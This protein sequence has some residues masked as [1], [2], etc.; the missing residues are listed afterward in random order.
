[1]AIERFLEIVCEAAHKLPQEIKQ[2]APDIDWRAM[3]DFAN[4]LRHAYHATN[5]DIVWNI[6]QHHLPALRAFVE[7][8]ARISSK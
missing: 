6:V 8:R 5:V 2:A 4:L 7:L 3:N 1:M